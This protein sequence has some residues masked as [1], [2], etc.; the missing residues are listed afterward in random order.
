MNRFEVLDVLVTKPL[1]CNDSMQRLSSNESNL[2]C[3]F[4]DSKAF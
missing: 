3:S 1:S 4:I 2:S